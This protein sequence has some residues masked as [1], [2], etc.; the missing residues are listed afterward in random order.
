MKN[1]KII[2]W[3]VGRRKTAVA[4]VRLISGDGKIKVNKKSMET[5]FKGYDVL[6]HEIMSP[7][8]LTDLTD[9]YNVFANV[10]GGGKTGQA[11][12]IRHGISRA[13][14]KLDET[15]RPVLKKE[16]LLTRDS[17]IVERKKPGRPKARKKFQYSKR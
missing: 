4:R 6:Q 7:L 8:K 14:L 2:Y 17:R 13:L 11:E 9:K 5:Y 10:K 15:T 1:K 12:A 16:G 3:G